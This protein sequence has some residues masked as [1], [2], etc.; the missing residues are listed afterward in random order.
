M[1][2][3]TQ[4]VENIYQLVYV[5][6]ATAPF[7]I[8]DIAAIE[9]VSVRNN[10]VLGL[11]GLLTYCDCKFMQFLEGE[12]TYVEKLFAK[13]KKDTRHHSIDIMREGYISE[14]QYT[15][16]SMRYTNIDDIQLHEG[17]VHKKLFENLTPSLAPYDKAKESLALLVSFK[18]SCRDQIYK[19]R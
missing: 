19:K 8:E 4:K 11:T 15:G 5:S 14:R 17:F 13:I 9:N 2:S 16:W 10:K 6:T 18:S 1:S 3:S 7:E 12:K